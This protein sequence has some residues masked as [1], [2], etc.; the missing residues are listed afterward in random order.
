[1]F[2]DKSYPKA[3]AI[4]F[5]TFFI[6]SLTEQSQCEENFS[7]LI[8]TKMETIYQRFSNS[9]IPLQQGVAVS[10][11]KNYA[12]VPAKVIEKVQ[13]I[14]A[15]ALDSKLNLAVIKLSREFNPVVFDISKTKD[16]VFF[17]FTFLDEPS[18]LIV[19]GKFKENKVELQG[20]QPLGSLLLSLD[21]I[22]LGVVTESG[23]IS[24]ALLIKPFY[25][26]IN[27]L[28]KRKPGWLGLQGQ[29]ITAELGKIMSVSEGVI[30]TNIY[31]GGPADKAKLRRGDII[32][33]ADNIKIRELK[34][35]QN[36]VSTKFAG[37][38]INLEVLRDGIRKTYLLILEEPPENF[39]QKR[40]PH[41]LPI[42]GVEVIEIPENVKTKIKKSING[43][44][45]KKVSEDSP[46]LGI[47][48]EEDIIVEI[49]K[50]SVNSYKDF[51]EI[52]QQIGNNDLLIL[53]YRQDSFQ[54]VIIPGQKSR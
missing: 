44:F 47:L 2:R 42:R 26:E 37:E 53:V 41:I 54:Y 6:L 14:S 20:R 52:I 45:V 38:S 32:V 34:D 22:P 8:K 35:L 24:E 50:K 5:I 33:E 21:L 13:N 51:N 12:I 46:A 39:I 23:S 43:V 25:S 28:I 9:L 1:M 36:I 4:L 7:T 29:T 19:K 31:E 40:T 15:V 3:I 27:K 18:L 49:N 30:V 17:L 48:K 16:E 11:D 10:I